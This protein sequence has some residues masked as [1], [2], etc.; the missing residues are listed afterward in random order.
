M[1]EP[2]TEEAEDALNLARETVKMILSFLPAA[3][4]S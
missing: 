1:D 4:K 2:N 3:V